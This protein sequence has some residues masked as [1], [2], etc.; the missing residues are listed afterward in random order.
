M[1]SEPEKIG[2]PRSSGPAR[3][4][5]FAVPLSGNGDSLRGRPQ[6]PRAS[7]E[8]EKLARLAPDLSSDLDFLAGGRSRV[9]RL[10]TTSRTPLDRSALGFPP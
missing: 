3:A 1:G 4:G 9:A 2:F 8:L 6:S 10:R 7:H 5:I